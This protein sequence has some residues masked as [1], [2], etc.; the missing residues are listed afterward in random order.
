MQAGIA[1]QLCDSHVDRVGA[2][3]FDQVGDGAQR[4]VDADL[5]LA[6]RAQAA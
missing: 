3:I 1:L 2:H 6:L 5:D 4:L